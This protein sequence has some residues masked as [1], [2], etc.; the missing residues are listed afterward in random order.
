V[1]VTVDG[2]DVVITGAGAKEIRLKPGR[3]KVEA[4]KDGTLVRRELV[5]VTRN[6]RQVVR[7]S[8]ESVDHVFNLRDPW[9]KS[10]AVLPAA[11]QVEAVA[12]RL[13]ELNPGFDGKVKPTIENSVVTGLEFSGDEVKDLLPV[14]VLDGLRVLNCEGSAPGKS[15]LEDLRPLSGLRLTI[16]NC[17]NTRVADLSPLRGCP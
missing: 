8:K 14:H 11:Q 5:T 13:Q 1:S 15:K 10:V 7:I 16:L 17:G 2:G 6:G 9:E 12:R 4:N 3:Y